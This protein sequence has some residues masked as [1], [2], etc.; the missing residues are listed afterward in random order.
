MS[1]FDLKKEVEK[2]KFVVAKKNLGG[3]VKAQ[4]VCVLDVSGSAEDLFKSGQM[5]EAFQRIL[6]VGI[7]FD[8]NQEIDVYTFASGSMIAHVEP[9]AVEGNFEDYIKQ[10]IL[11]NPKVPKW[12]GTDYAPVTQQILEDF[13]FYKIT[14]TPRI[15]KT[16]GGFFSRAKEETVYDETKELAKDSKSG[17]PV[18]V[19]FFTDGANADQG[20]TVRLFAEMEKAGTQLYTL[21]VGIGGANF[22]N[23]V[24]LG[25]K[26]G[27]VGFLNV[28]DI[29]KLNAD[30]AIYDKLL[31]DELTDWLKQSR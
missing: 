10:N 23:I 22:S 17:D 19:Y 6:P 8:L 28:S 26:F 1:K 27:N 2:V 16:G 30:E 4:V 14:K 12:G 21:F 20:A 25:D 11:N 15:V 18:I 9:T 5:Q 3:S 13:E 24:K 7:T 31:P 29:K